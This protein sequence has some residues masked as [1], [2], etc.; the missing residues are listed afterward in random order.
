MLIVDVVLNTVF[1]QVTKLSTKTPLLA[2]L[3]TNDW[4]KTRLLDNDTDTHAQTAVY[5]QSD[6]TG[7]VRG[8]EIL[9]LRSTGSRRR[10]ADLV[11]REFFRSIAHCQEAE[12]ED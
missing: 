12:D 9:H 8:G 4:Q 7:R 11:S 3:R 2:P 5:L 6:G 1:Q 10:N